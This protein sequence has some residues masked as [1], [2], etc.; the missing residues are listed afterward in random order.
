MR[1]NPAYSLDTIETAMCLWEALLEN[2]RR[3]DYN[4]V[5]DKHGAWDLRH[6]CIALASHCDDVWQAFEGNDLWAFDWE[7][8]PVYVAHCVDWE[9]STPKPV[10]DCLTIIREHLKQEEA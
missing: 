6:R 4:A 2:R 1:G 9:T 10:A 5:W 8:C 3:E 7:Y